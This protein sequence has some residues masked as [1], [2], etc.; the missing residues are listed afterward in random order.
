[1]QFYEDESAKAA[2]KQ[3]LIVALM[4]VH[5]ARLSGN[6]RAGFPTK[7]LNF[8][9]AIHCL[10]PK[11]SEIETANLQGVSKRHIKRFSA[12]CHGPPVIH[13]MDKEIALAV[14]KQI[15][16]VRG[17]SGN[18][19]LRVAMSMGV[20][21]TVISQAFQY[22][23][24]HN[25]VIGGAYPNNW[26]EVGSTNKDDIQA[27]LKWCLD[28][29]FGDAAAEVKVAILSFQFTPPVFPPYLILVGQTQSIYH[30]NSFASDVMSL[31]LQAAKNDGNAVILNEST[32]GVFWESKANIEHQKLYLTGKSDQLSFTDTCHNVKNNRSQN[33]GG[34][35]ATP[36]SSGSYCFDSMLLKMAGVP[37]E[38]V[39]IVDFASDALV[40]KLASAATV[41]VCYSY[42]LMILE[43]N[44]KC[45]PCYHL[46]LHNLSLLIQKHHYA[47]SDHSSYA[48][49]HANAF[50]CHQLSRY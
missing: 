6:T 30:S 23:A 17:R 49:F 39:H 46:L 3:S 37:K 10:S 42:K 2:N 31:C 21:A 32:D 24:S 22:L 26:L 5:L 14:E 28:G 34:S 12:K 44:G 40:L 43:Q 36:A 11:A 33:V 13:L 45:L 47:C 1:M 50:I 16:M 25:A 7:V 15:K 18:K 9:M 38:V 27:V 19:S 29:E 41:R 8:F 48:A 4:D 20:D 35:G